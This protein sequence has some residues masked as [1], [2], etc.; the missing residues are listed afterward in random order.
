MTAT[1]Q[2]P[3]P[4]NVSD[5]GPHCW[6]TIGIDKMKSG[7]MQMLGHGLYVVNLF[8][9]SRRAALQG[10]KESQKH[11]QKEAKDHSATE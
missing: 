9:E 2:T 11:W 7:K 8:S 4:G 1:K 5:R 3:K 10:G 6:L